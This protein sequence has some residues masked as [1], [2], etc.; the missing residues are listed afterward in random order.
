PP[1]PP[2]PPPQ[3]T[4]PPPPYIPPPKIQVQ[5][6]PQ[7]VIQHVTHTPPPKPMPPAVAAP[8]TPGPVGPPVPDHLAGSRPINHVQLT[9]PEQAEEEGREGKVTVVCDVEPS[10][11]TS[12]CS[13]TSV[14]GGQVFAQ[15]ALDYVR[16]AR[17]APATQN[18]VPIKE[19]HHAY[20]ITFS[21]NND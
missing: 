9:Y 3:L 21:L 2:P 4:T 6:P 10:G 19:F 15:A 7:Q 14:Q 13:V 1:P 8:P 12:N 18:G 5:P 17:Y 16:R 20:T 11:E